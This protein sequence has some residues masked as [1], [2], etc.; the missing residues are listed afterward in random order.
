MNWIKKKGVFL[1]ANPKTDF[2]PSFLPD[3]EVERKVK[4]EIG[5]VTL[6][7]VRNRV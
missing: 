6:E 1:S 5:F 3:F 7:N 2:D 4:S